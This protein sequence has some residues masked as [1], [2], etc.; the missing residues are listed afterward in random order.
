MEILVK[1][2]YLEGICM[3]EVDPHVVLDQYNMESL[4]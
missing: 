4:K 3:V 2:V 1:M